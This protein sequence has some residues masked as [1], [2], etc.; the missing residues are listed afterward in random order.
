MKKSGENRPI[1][2]V[3]I[4]SV[5]IRRLAGGAAKWMPKSAQLPPLPGLPPPGRAVEVEP[6]K[7]S[8]PPP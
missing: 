8:A 5:E 2:P 3:A 4:E 6:P 7:S 1:T